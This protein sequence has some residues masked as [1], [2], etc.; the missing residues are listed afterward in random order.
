VRVSLDQSRDHGATRNV[1]RS[2]S[3]VRRLDRFPADYD[4][5]FGGGGGESVPD[6]SPAK[7]KAAHRGDST[8]RGTIAA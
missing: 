5:A 7:C 8:L 2:G 3:L 6:V 1:Y 4:G